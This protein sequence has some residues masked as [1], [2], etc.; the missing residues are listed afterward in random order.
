MNTPNPSEAREKQDWQLRV[1]EEK[2]ELDTKIA[3]LR[4]FIRSPKFDTVSQ[5]EQWR[6]TT[7][8]HTMV[9]YSAILGARIGEWQ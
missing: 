6:M 8:M 4:V 9:Q 3:N 1:V 2:S 7:Q 5:S